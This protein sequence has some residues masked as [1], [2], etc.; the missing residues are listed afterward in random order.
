MRS[1]TPF[2]VASNPADDYTAC[3]DLFLQTRAPL[4]WQHEVISIPAR[5]RFLQEAQNE[6]VG[7]SQHAKEAQSFI[8]AAW[9]LTRAE[10]RR[11]R[12]AGKDL[13]KPHRSV[14]AIAFC[15][16]VLCVLRDATAERDASAARRCTQ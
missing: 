6:L 11:R 15:D 16:L 3:A 13:R 2:P 10:I 1:V 4:Q 9:R 14:S 7:Q 12:A 8:D 5:L